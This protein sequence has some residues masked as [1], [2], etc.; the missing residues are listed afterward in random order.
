MP[1]RPSRG[2]L[3]EAADLRLAIRRFHSVTERI[4]REFGLTYRQYLLLLVIE[5]A[6]RGDRLS[7]GNLSSALKLAASSMTE[8]VDRGVEAGLLE[9]VQADHDARVF[10]VRATR[11]GRKRMIKAFRALAS[12]RASLATTAARLL[13]GAERA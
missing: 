11:E 8:L 5:S 6:P 12:E 7:V 10:Y 13:D 9:R 2:E 1:P 3:R 4:V